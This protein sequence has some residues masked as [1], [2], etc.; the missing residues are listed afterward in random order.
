M[1]EYIFGRPILF[2]VHH[3]Q[4]LNCSVH[5]TNFVYERCAE[6]GS[7][8]LEN[9]TGPP[10]PAD[11][12]WFDSYNM[13]KAQDLYPT[14][15]LPLPSY[16]MAAA[17]AAGGTSAS[18][19]TLPVVRLDYMM[20]GAFLSR[21][22]RASAAAVDAQQLLFEK[23]VPSVAI[24]MRRGD[25]TPADRIRYTPNEYYI[26]IV[27]QI[28]SAVSTPV[29]VHVFSSLEGQHAEDEFKPLRE[30]QMHVHLEQ[31]VQAKQS[32]AHF[33]KANILIMAK[34]AFSSVPALLREKCVIY[35]PYHMGKLSNWVTA[36]QLNATYI[37]HCLSMS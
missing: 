10:W 17:E 14:E 3:L 5:Q 7:S 9:V 27:R 22:R 28:R 1:A 19:L 32:W 26:D 34:S 25:V 16:R 6:A 35:E 24:H 11:V 4:S 37:Q 36:D 8:C 30:Q 33:A 21:L 2:Q 12:I 23:G 18:Q 15:H 29:Q 31:T 20:S 13:H